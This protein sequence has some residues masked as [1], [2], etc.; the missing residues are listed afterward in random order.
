MT[1]QEKH[2]KEIWEMAK[3]NLGISAYYGQHKQEIDKMW[4]DTMSAGCLSTALPFMVCLYSRI[5]GYRKEEEVQKETAKKILFRVKLFLDE[6]TKT[7]K[8]LSRIKSSAAIPQSCVECYEGSQDNRLD[9]LSRIAK[10]FGVEVE[11]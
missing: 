1:E 4:E 6:Q 7:V 2:E 5:A 3:R 11:E 9:E 8:H 10:D